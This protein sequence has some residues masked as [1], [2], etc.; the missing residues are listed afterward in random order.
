MC[1]ARGDTA[2]EAELELRLGICEAGH[3]QRNAALSHLR[4]AW[5]RLPPGHADRWRA[6]FWLGLQH[7]AQ[8]DFARAREILEEARA[9]AITAGPVARLRIDYEIGGIQAAMGDWAALERVGARVLRETGGESDDALALRLDA[10]HALGCVAC[11]RGA[12][13]DAWGHF[14][15]SRILADQCGH[16]VDRALA[17]W[18][19]AGNVLAALGRWGEARAGLVELAATAPGWVATVSRWYGLWLDGRWEDAAAEAV[20]SLLDYGRDSDVEAQVGV[21]M[22]ILDV[23]LALGRDHEAL[24]LVREL[25]GRPALRDAAGY[26]VRLAPYE[27]EAMARLRDPRVCP[28][29]AE[30]LDLA[31]RLGA[32]REEALFLCARARAQRDCGDWHGAFGASDAAVAIFHELGMPYEEARALRRAAL[33]RLDRGRRGDRD[34]AASA[35]HAARG[36]FARIGAHRDAADVDQILSGA[37]LARRGDRPSPPGLDRLSAREREV[38][39]AIAEGLTNRQIAARLYLSER[40]VAHHVSAILTKQGLDS[41]SQIAALVARAGASPNPHN[42]IG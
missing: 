30:G 17:D 39:G 3:R 5:G 1:H 32:R 13:Q 29:I 23:Q 25:L 37:G 40:T 12:F 7:A 38:A 35:L 24:A 21:A 42:L 34:R 22:R 4:A 16:L 36:V 33:L 2:R 8:G 28:V 9:A 18:N 11:Y 6:G 26:A 19:V 20:Q 27:A 15:A 31:R 10:H 41:R 14:R